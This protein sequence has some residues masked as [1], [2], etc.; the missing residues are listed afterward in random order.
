M[1]A[2]VPEHGGDVVS[3][4]RVADRQAGDPLEVQVIQMPD[5]AGLDAYLRDPRRADLAR[6]HSRD[7]IIART[8]LLRLQDHD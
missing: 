7:E 5:E 6:I 1:L 3:R 4:D 2:L 8:Q